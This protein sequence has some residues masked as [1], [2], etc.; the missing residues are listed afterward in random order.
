MR[1]WRTFYEREV[2]PS[3]QEKGLGEIAVLGGIISP[4]LLLLEKHSVKAVLLCKLLEV[5]LC[6]LDAPLGE[7]WPQEQ[8]TML[9]K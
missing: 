5:D 7:V 6:V 2:F 9:I 4:S 8:P 1:G 3:S